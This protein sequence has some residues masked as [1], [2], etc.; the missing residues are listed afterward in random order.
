[1]RVSPTT[2]QVGD[3]TGGRVARI[4]A[5][6]LKIDPQAMDPKTP[7]ALYGLDSVGSVEL[8]AALEE[9]FGREL[10]EWLLLDHPDLDALVRALDAELQR[11]LT[12]IHAHDTVQSGSSCMPSAVPSDSSRTSTALSQMLADS[13]LPADIRPPDG[14]VGATPRRVL[15][16]G[17]TGFLGAYL[18]RDLLDETEAEIWCLVRG[19]DNEVH[20]RVARTLE[21]YGLDLPGPGTRVHIVSGDLT[22]PNLGLSSR[23]YQ[24]LCESLDEVYHAAAD[25]NWVLPY[26]ALRHANVIATRE[27]LRLAC[28]RRPKVFHFVSSLS[29]CYATVGPAEVQ[30]DDDMLPHVDRLPLGYAQ[31]KCVAESL[32]RHAAA[33]GLPV[34]IHR[35]PL[36][37]GDS[38]TGASN[39]EDLVALLLKGCIQ[40]G[41]APDLDWTFDAMPVDFVS[42]AIV[43]L[44]R[45]PRHGYTSHLHHPH[46]RHWRE[47]VLWMN[48]F[49]Y[50]VRLLPFPEWQQLLAREADS[51][52]HALHPLRSFFLRR[53]TGFERPNDSDDL[54]VAELYE[55]GRR[56]TVRGD[57]TRQAVS[58]VGLECP[59]LDARLFDRYFTSYLDRGFLP[60]PTGKAC[61]RRPIAQATACYEDP[62]FLERLL[63]QDSGDP[64][65]RIRDVTLAPFGTDHSIISELTSWRRQRPTGLHRCRLTVERAGA[66][67]SR[68]H[69]DVV[70][71][72]KPSDRDAI[73]VGETVATMCDERLGQA[74]REFRDRIGLTSSHLRELAIYQQSDDRM[75][76]HLPRCFG[77]WQDDEAEE[78]GLALEN[79]QDLALMNAIEPSDWSPACIDAAIV[80]L[81]EIHAVWYGRDR[82]LTCAPWLGEPLSRDRALDLTPL[83][84]ALAAHAA[85]SF[86]SWGGPSVAR[87]HSQL[88]ESIAEW[89]QPLDLQPRTLIHNDFS[90]RNVALRQ[91]ANGLRLCAYDWE[92]AT[93]GPPQRDLAEFLCFVLE[94]SA[95]AQAVERLVERHRSLLEAATGQRI[96]AGLWH[97]GFRSALADL[98]IDKLAFYA[99]V[100]RIRSQR[101]LPRVVRT[102]RRLFELCS[103]GAAR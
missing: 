50:P 44:A 73:E 75:R 67:D 94:P 82:E 81:S 92:L 31:T 32:T 52:R 4:V 56:S 7:L 38:E 58:A 25:V 76:R 8:V 62:K 39:L 79:L 13:F 77:T 45:A 89:W 61:S 55:E 100:N 19:N 53:Q 65:L 35:P 78:W 1:V 20:G 46:Q 42:R 69:V 103:Q 101:F 83:W 3:E 11:D 5:D 21:R 57:L 29:V 41:A 87:T 17:A 37:V 22:R 49:G 98:L 70:I 84:R 72:A 86:A 95:T 88:V 90:P 96:P 64:C 93:L 91:D 63:R 15:L 74:F 97:Q 47:C 10:P 68:D 51:P 23:H 34:H 36:I 28:A 2:P 102:W 16:T 33:R 48:L 99:M 60:K 6:F 71:K 80:G 66:L 40:M 26:G 9:A 24:E 43:R 59:R 14:Q 30:E 12:A 27:L 85:P 54:S 18:L